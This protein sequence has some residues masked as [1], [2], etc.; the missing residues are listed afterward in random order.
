MEKLQ[1]EQSPTVDWLTVTCKKSTSR[2]ALFDIATQELQ[3]LKAEGN[4]LKTWRFHGY[5]GLSCQGYRWGTR[6]DSDI[7]MLSGSDAAYGWQTALEYATNVTRIDLA[8]TVRL[9]HPI[10][11]YAW[12]IYRT[13][14]EKVDGKKPCRKLTFITNNHG[15]QTLYVGSRSSDQMGRLYD[16]GREGAKKLDMPI[17]ELWRYEVELKAK[18]ALAVAEQLKIC[19]KS[20]QNVGNAIGA[21]VQTWFFT[22]GVPSLMWP[23][24]RE[25][26]DLAIAAR[27]TDDAATLDWLSTCV[28]P[29]VQRLIKK[30][31][32]RDVLQSLGFLDLDKGL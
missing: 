2:V 5:D 7:L 32:R 12:A 13:L 14:D 10:P 20:G 29:S 9:F 26:F 24:S 17:G 15:G 3:R 21:T 31:R 4:D 27:I 19:A 8:V 11:D 23:E 30:G 16:K 22:R 18:R 1:R 25:E 6:Q 28:K